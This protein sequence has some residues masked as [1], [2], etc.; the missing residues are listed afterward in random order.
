MDVGADFELG[1]C[2]RRTF[3]LGIRDKYINTCCLQFF[4]TVSAIPADRDGVGAKVN[5]LKLD[6]IVRTNV[7]SQ[8]IINTDDCNRVSDWTFRGGDVV[9]I[10]CI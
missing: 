6:V 3:R 8:T 1:D 4:S 9:W 5:S 7:T 2:N 10:S